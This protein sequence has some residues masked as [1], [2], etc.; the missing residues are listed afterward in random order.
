ME[1]NVNEK[2]PYKG[3]L[4]GV[5]FTIIIAIVGMAITYIPFIGKFIGIFIIMGSPIIAILSVIEENKGIAYENKKSELDIPNDAM[6]VH[7]ISGLSSIVNCNHYLWVDNGFLCF[8]PKDHDEFKKSEIETHFAL[9]KLTIDNIDYYTTKGNVYS[10]TKINGGGGGGVSIGGAILGN[11]IAGSVGAVIAGRKKVNEVT[12]ENIVHD[13][14]T[15]DIYYKMD[16]KLYI[17]KLSFS[18]YDKLLHLIPKKSYEYKLL[19]K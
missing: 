7:V 17:V 9:G 19:N 6:T 5:F 10:E 16:N 14:R 15:T 12:S 11:V 4:R 18:D 2:E 13:S 1:E 8:F 3:F